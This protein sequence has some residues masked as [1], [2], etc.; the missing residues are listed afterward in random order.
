MIYILQFDPQMHHARYYVGWCEDGRLDER[1]TEHKK[2][3][4]AKITRA[5]VEKGIQLALVAT[6]PGDRTRERAIKRQKNT[7]RLVKQLMNKRK[8]DVGSC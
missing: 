5:A 1:L 2:G 6:L 4:G 3:R 8:I 7:P